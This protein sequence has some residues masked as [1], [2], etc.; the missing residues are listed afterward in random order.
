MHMQIKFEAKNKNNKQQTNKRIHDVLYVNWIE[1]DWIERQ[2][3]NGLYSR[4]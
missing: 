4:L 3:N 2:V 1:L